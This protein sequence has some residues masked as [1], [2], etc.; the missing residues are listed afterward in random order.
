M[1][2]RITNI[3]RLGEEIEVTMRTRSC[4]FQGGE[5][6]EVK[7]P[8]KKKSDSQR[9][10]FHTLSDEMAEAVKVSKIY[11]KNHLLGRYGQR[12][13]EEDGTPRQVLVRE[14]VDMMEQELIHCVLTGYKEVYNEETD[15]YEMYAVWDVIKH[16]ADYTSKEMN[17]LIEGTVAEAKEIGGIDTTSPQE[18]ERMERD[19]EHYSKRT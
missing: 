16:T 17:A 3:V 8:S 18:R 5:L 9:R 15:D 6:V 7:L 2:S 10:F 13:Y 11:M 14:D 19:A 4:E 1:I 12:E